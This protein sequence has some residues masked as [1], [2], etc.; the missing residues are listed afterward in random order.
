M[1]LGFIGLGLGLGLGLGGLTLPLE[2]NCGRPARPAIWSTSIMLYSSNCCSC[3]EYL[4][5]F[6]STTRCAGRLTP[7]A[8]P[9]VVQSTGSAP[10]EK[11]W[12]G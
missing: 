12:L 3:A 10:S 9:L 5:V 2:S 1:V 6:S 8:R 11:S 7:C 4:D